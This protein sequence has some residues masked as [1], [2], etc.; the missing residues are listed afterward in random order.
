MFSCVNST[1]NSPCI[2]EAKHIFYA[3]WLEY[4]DFFPFFVGFNKL[5]KMEFNK[6]SKLETIES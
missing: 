3:N 1:S 2:K 6:Q 5:V 4:S